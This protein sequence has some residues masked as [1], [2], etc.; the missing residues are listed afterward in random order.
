MN[1]KVPSAAVQDCARHSVFTSGPLHSQQESI[2]GIVSEEKTESQ[3]VLCTSPRP[4]RWELTQQTLE[5]SD[6]ASVP[7]TYGVCMAIG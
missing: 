6:L 7:S 1:P 3:R 5:P 4:P 2:L